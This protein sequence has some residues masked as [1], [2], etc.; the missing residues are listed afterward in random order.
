MAIYGKWIGG[1]L[2]WALGG[3]IGGILG[4]VFGSMFDNMQ[5][6]EFEYKPGS[7]PTQ[8]GDFAVSLLILSAAVMKADSRVLKS[9]LDYVRRFFLQQF[10]KG[11]TEESMLMLKDILKQNIPLNDVCM[12]INRFMEYEVKLQLLH[13]LFGISKA[14]GQT[15]LRE[16]REIED[17][18][19]RIG[20]KAAD[21]KSIRSMFAADINAA[22]NILQITPDDSD[23]EIKKAY[24]KLAV[25]Y[26]P[27]KVSHL[28]E[29]IQRAAKEKFQKINAAYNEIK[30][31]RGMN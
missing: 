26:H 24:R 23:E 15:H 7:T 25:K 22:Y 29:D 3:P 20:I 9:E 11:K 8:Q 6:G 30:K 1:G 10:G 31:Q 13:Y 16:I 18:S 28:G 14:D 27:D 4:F 12:Q 17:I 21:M 5:K 2:G 19:N